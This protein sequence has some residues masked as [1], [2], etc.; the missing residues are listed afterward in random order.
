MHVNLVEVKQPDGAFDG[1]LI[2]TSHDIAML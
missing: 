2:N 1:E